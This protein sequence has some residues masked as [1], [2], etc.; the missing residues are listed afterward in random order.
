[1]CGAV[2]MKKDLWEDCC[3]SL[4]RRGLDDH[5]DSSFLFSE[6]DFTSV[7]REFRVEYSNLR[8]FTAYE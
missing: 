2:S 5:C 1:M 3:G 7:D 4:K 6:L 8:D